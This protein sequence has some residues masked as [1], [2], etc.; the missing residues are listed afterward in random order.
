M[1]VCPSVCPSASITGKPCGRTSPN[2]VCLLPMAVAR[3][4]CDGVAIRY[5]LPVLRMTSCFHTVGPIGGRTGTTLCTAR[6]LPLAERRPLWVSRP[7]SLHAAV[8]LPR[9]PRT[10]DVTL[11]TALQSTCGPSQRLCK[12]SATMTIEAA[13]YAVAVWRLVFIGDT[14]PILPIIYPL[15]SITTIFWPSN[16]MKIIFYSPCN[17][18]CVASRGSD[19]HEA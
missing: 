8:L 19:L 9:R 17:S 18:P 3:S 5:V 15:H 16:S 2:F 12:Q 6:R 14:S 4:S 7:T 13:I 11:A 10:R 1:S